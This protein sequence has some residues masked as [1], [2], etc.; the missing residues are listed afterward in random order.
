MFDLP[1]RSPLFLIDFLIQELLV[2]QRQHD[3]QM[4]KINHMQVEE[5]VDS[6]LFQQF[7]RNLLINFDTMPRE[8]LWCNLASRLSK[9]KMLL[10]QLKKRV[11]ALDFSLKI[12]DN[13]DAQLF[14]SKESLLDMVTRGYAHTIPSLSILAYLLKIANPLFKNVH[15]SIDQSSRIA[16]V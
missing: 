10:K 12:L 11:M 1:P 16:L 7:F 2:Q 3:A 5:T 9:E 8:L 4:T 14:K 13:W 6:F 15:L